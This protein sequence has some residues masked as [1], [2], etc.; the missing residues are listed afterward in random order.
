MSCS[1]SVNKNTN[2]DPLFSERTSLRLT[3][4]K[5]AGAMIGTSR[6]QQMNDA[7]LHTFLLRRNNQSIPV[8]YNDIIKRRS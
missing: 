2:V 4:E 1:S 3:Q 8:V 5:M 6:A 7:T